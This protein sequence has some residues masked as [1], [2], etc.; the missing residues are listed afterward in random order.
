MK[1]KLS[2]FVEKLG[3][4]F[5]KEEIDDSMTQYL[6]RDGYLA[7]FEDGYGELI[8]LKAVSVQFDE[9]GEIESYNLEYNDDCDGVEFEPKDSVIIEVYELKKIV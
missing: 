6:V 1:V 4:Y 3:E 2:K 9:D 7:K 8:E 5:I